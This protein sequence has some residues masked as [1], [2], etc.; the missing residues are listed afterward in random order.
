MTATI[1]KLV[2]A[3]VLAT[4]VPAAASARDCDHARDARTAAA[5]A[6][7]VRPAPPPGRV[8]DWR[9]REMRALRAELRALEREHAAFHARHAK[10]PGKLRQH[11]RSYLERRAQLER[12]MIALR[13]VAWR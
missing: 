10:H 9:D 7:P 4:S 2:L 5:H 12:R 13:A 3:A 6:A 11:D 1:P 8:A